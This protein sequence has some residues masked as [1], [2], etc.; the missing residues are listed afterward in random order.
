MKL[1]KTISL[2]LAALPVYALASNTEP[3]A[4]LNKTA[5]KA[6]IERMMPGTA[7]YFAIEEIP[8]SNGKDVFEIAHRGNQ[9]LLSG[10]NGVAIASAFNYYLKHI[11]HCQ[12]TWNGSNR[13]LAF[14]LPKPTQPIRKI[15]PYQYRYYLNYCT[16]NYTMSWWDWKRWQ[17]EIDW[18]A[19]NG[20][21]A[22]L[23]LTGQNIIHSRVYK[24]LGLTDLDLANFFSGPAYFSWFWMGN[25]DAWGGP[26]PQSWM[27]QHEKLQQQIVARERELGMKPI[28]PAFTGHVPPAFKDRYPNAKLN[29]TSWNNKFPDVYLLNPADT[30]FIQIGK[31]FIL[32]QTKAYGTDHLYSADTFNENKPPSNDSLFLSDISKKVY[33]S[34]AAADPKAVWVMQGW[35][36]HFSAKFWQQKQIKAMLNAVPD[37]K[38][39]ILD[40]W[41]E[42]NPLWQKTHAYHGKPWI[43][44]M[45]SNFGG[46]IS[47]QG[48]MDR[49]ASGPA[50]ALK[51]PNAGNMVGIGLTPEGIE[52]NPVMYELMMENV[53]EE[54][55]IK[56]DKWLEG[57]AIRR[58]K[59]PNAKAQ[60]AWELLRKSVYS[61]TLT[62]GGPES[63]ICARPTL[64]RHTRGVTTKFPYD[65]KDLFQAWQ[66]LIQSAPKLKDAEGFQY[67]LVDVSRQVLAN[68]AT[69]LQQ[70]AAQAYQR[71]EIAKYKKYSQEFLA[72]INNLDQL[73]ATRPD[74]LL[75]SWLNTAKAWGTNQEEK[76]QYERNARNLITLWGNE[77]STLREYACKQWS[78]LLNGFYKP[79]WQE[80]FKQTTSALQNNQ[81]FDENAFDHQMKKWEWNWVNQNESYPNTVKGNPVTE[82]TRIFKQYHQQIQND[83]IN[84]KLEPR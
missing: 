12:I 65:N 71:N 40:L 5:A 54:Q 74:F 79:R 18:M 20:I 1:I 77:N 51:H 34:M 73:L 11:A 70:K 35:L 28:L 38:M 52:Q 47:M 53:W 50:L 7:A 8:A 67:D 45:L 16:F 21:N 76:K 17:W 61:D 80:F 43:W 55:P 6:L 57:Y 31:R 29:K 81:K 48:T 58:Y 3:P 62:N 33:Q 78:G 69:Y 64:A 59:R 23:A 72:L 56:L 49:V 13:K 22:P 4:Q 84:F 10:N 37:D 9:I 27:K 46:N 66:L 63:I 19:M 24:S 75:G 32:E 26:L 60:L 83:F 14:P 68:Y 2:F 36:F 30:M 39:I 41:S 42:R 15:S 25:L 82:A 44:N